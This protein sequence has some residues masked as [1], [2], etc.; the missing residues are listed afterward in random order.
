MTT[1]A[2]AH[3]AFHG[4]WCWEL[5]TPLLQDAGHDV[6]AVDMP[7][8]DGAA[9][10]ED[11]AD[12]VCA[13][14]QEHD[15]VVLV[16]HSFAG[17]VIPLVAARRPLKHLVYLC[18]VV[19][20]LGSSVI[21]QLAS[22]PDMISPLFYEGLGELDDQMRT[23]FADLELAR[24]IFYA[25]C[26]DSVAAAAVARLSPQSALPPSQCF[27]LSE[28]PS[29]RTTYVMCRDDQAVGAEWA[30]RIADERLHADLVE[31]PGG[32]SPFYSRPAVLADVLL[33]LAV[34]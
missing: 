32:H 10:F 33:G 19:P 24:K 29:V 21:E 23:P 9:S 25:D 34:A 27:T 16:G 3:G 14:L 22:E 28:F 11:C 2:L 18:A 6:V 26:D 17:C 8:D 5:L 31:L 7:F 20:A 30:R 13:A 15:D 4:A 12:V 1:F